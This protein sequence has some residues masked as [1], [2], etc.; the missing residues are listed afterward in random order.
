[1]RHVWAVPEM[2][3]LSQAKK[4]LEYHTKAVGEAEAPARLFP[5]LDTVMPGLDQTFSVSGGHGGLSCFV[6]R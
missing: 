6:Q 3:Q 5:E 2:S 4:I 1:L